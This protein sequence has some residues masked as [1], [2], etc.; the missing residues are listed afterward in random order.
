[1]TIA[2]PSP[3]VG[4]GGAKRRMRGCLRAFKC[5]S[6]QGGENPSPV[7]P[8]RGEPPSPTR[9]EGRPPPPRSCFGCPGH[10]DA[11]PG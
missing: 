2:F 5:E 11:A 3:L 9:G 4:E 7:S 1:M 8:L 10:D 6:S